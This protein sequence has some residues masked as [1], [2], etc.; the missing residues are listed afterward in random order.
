MDESPGEGGNGRWLLQ[1]KQDLDT[2]ETGMDL[3][4]SP[5]KHLVLEVWFPV[6]VY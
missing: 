5:D 2:L 3:A 6:F 1:N 4:L